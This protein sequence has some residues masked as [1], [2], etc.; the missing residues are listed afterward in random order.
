MLLCNSGRN[1]PVITERY[2]VADFVHLLRGEALGL[3][4][5]FQKQAYVVDYPLTAQPSFHFSLGK[6][7]SYGQHPKV[8]IGIQIYALP[9]FAVFP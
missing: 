3:A 8:L 6:E 4:A 2:P 7:A 1:V 5:R 9:K